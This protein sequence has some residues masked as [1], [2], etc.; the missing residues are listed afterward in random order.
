MNA[1]NTVIVS[2]TVLVSALI[3]AAA[4]FLVHRYMI[5]EQP[6]S[7][8]A[9]KLDR[10]TGQSYGCENSPEF[11]PFCIPAPNHPLVTKFGK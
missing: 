5:V 6:G 7:N 2:A 9:W 3:W 4:I 11:G 8:V 1:R 10:L